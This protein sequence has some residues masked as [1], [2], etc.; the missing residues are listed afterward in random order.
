M[1]TSLVTRRYHGGRVIASIDIDFI[2][3]RLNLAALPQ[4]TADEPEHGS[5]CRDEERGAT[6]ERGKKM[7]NRSHQGAS[8]NG[9]LLRVHV[10][11]RC[12]GAAAE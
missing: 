6:E 3:S 2:P 7:E 8:Y 12:S 1:P 9:L 10:I 4:L 11:R 5:R